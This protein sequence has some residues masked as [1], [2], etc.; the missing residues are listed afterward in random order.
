MAVGN[1]Y[2]L[3][4]LFAL[5]SYGLVEIPK[6]LWYKRNRHLILKSLHF[7]AVGLL[8]ELE[9]S[10]QELD[11]TIKL[12]KKYADNI[13]KD[14]AFRPFVETIIKKCPVHYNDLLA[15]EGTFDLSYDKIVSLHSRIINANIAYSRSRCIYEEFFKGSV[16]FR[17]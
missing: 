6:R 14:H 5:L 1:I 4:L 9:Q 7:K 2:G 3:L 12:V 17:R 11:S 8:D 15:G 16:C 13:K 10:K